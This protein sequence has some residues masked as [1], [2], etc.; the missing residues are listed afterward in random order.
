MKLRRE[1]HQGWST[2]YALFAIVIVSIAIGVCMSTT[3][4]S[5][6]LIQRARDYT[7]ARLAAEGAIEYAWGAWKN[8]IQQQ[9]GLS[10]TSSAAALVSGTTV[11]GISA[12][13]NCTG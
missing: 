13:R 11:L 2:L 5:R 10:T 9:G 1:N 7:A 4:T 3:S 6:K 8:D 12:G